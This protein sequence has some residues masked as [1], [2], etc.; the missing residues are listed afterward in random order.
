M[1]ERYV[2]TV[3]AFVTKVVSIEAFPMYA[4]ATM[5]DGTTVGLTGSVVGLGR[6]YPS[7]GD[8]YVQGDGHSFFTTADALRQRYQKQ[9]SK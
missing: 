5:K 6:H 4:V 2:R 9:V 7:V 3:E 8:F 1:A